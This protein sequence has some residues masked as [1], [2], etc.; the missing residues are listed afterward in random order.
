[1]HFQLFQ[2]RTNSGMPCLFWPLPLVLFLA[3]AAAAAVSSPG[4]DRRV[5][6]EWEPAAGTLIAWP[7]EIPDAL[8]VELAKDD[9]IYVL[10][11]SEDA[12]Q[13][14]RRKIIA[15]GVADGRVHV[16][17]SS[18]QSCWPRDYGS[19][20]LFDARGILRHLD[21]IYIDTPEFPADPEPI[22]KGDHIKYPNAWPGDDRTNGAVATFFDAPLDAFPGFLT[23][24]NFLVDGQGTA[25]S[26]RALLDENLVMWSEDE[27]RA[28]V[29]KLAGIDRWVV[30]GN[31]EDKGI[32][33]IDCWLKVLDEETLLVKRPPADHPEA[34]RIER[35][36]ETL[37]GLS[38]AFGRP[39]RIVRIDCPRYKEDRLAA[40]T[41]S[42]ILN[43]KVLV[44]LF[45]IPADDLALET[46][47]QAMPGY[48]VKGFVWDRWWN[49]D[50]VH[51]RTR[52]MFD[53]GMLH[54]T[55]ARL[56]AAPAS[57]H[58]YEVFVTV[59]DM[60]RAGLLEDG[61]RV[62][63]RRGSSEWARVAL[64][65]SVAPGTWSGE[66]P[67]QP[68]GSTIEYYVEAASRSGRTETLPRTAPRGFYAFDVGDGSKREP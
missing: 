42:L 38:N 5:I 65:P 41:N 52:A 28:L 58:G 27:M 39:Y 25:F 63:W 37:R 20:Q 35:N 67:R 4:N 32:Q 30:L 16:I 62:F 29:R 54:L 3:L 11:S 31:T 17:P 57:A 59:E 55:H 26:T 48:D 49:V 22:R 36:L 56:R 15:L 12:G 61:V 1:M 14:A 33:H 24:G 18:V 51:C 64:R 66:I 40:Y 46:Y 34:A 19:H 2:Q 47:R 8:V 43:R 10:V 44:P 68:A 45:G 50:A 9:E 6:A 7:L 60:S 23:G 13:E 53:K 21:P